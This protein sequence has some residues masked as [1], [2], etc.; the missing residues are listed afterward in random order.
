MNQRKVLQAIYSLITKYKNG[1][2][3]LKHIS[4]IMLDEDKIYVEMGVNK[5][6]ISI[7]DGGPIL[8]GPPMDD[9]S[10]YA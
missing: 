1:D 4:N 9:G 10:D 6:T 2:N 7:E 5:F 8:S 3:R